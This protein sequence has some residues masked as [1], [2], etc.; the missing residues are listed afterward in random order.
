MNSC[1]MDHRSVLGLAGHFLSC[2]RVQTSD[3]HLQPADVEPWCELGQLGPWGHMCLTIS[4]IK[5]NKREIFLKGRN[6]RGDKG[7][8]SCLYFKKPKKRQNFLHGD[9]KRD[10][11][12]SSQVIHIETI[13]ANLR[14]KTKPFKPEQW[15]SLVINTATFDYPKV[16]S[17]LLRNHCSSNVPQN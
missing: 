15:A 8:L 1:C 16:S 10:F 9:H 6:H 4:L 12:G 3:F 5:T 14:H 17:C 13:C 2:S 7:L 11:I